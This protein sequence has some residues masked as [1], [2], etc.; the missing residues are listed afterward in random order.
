MQAHGAI[1]F[2]LG[3]GPSLSVFYSC[4]MRFLAAVGMVEHSISIGRAVSTPLFEPP[5]LSLAT[6][7]WLGV[8]PRTS[9]ACTV[10]TTFLRR[11]QRNPH[12][13]PRLYV[14]QDLWSS[15]DGGSRRDRR[16]RGAGGAQGR[17]FRHK[18]SRRKKNM[19]VETYWRA[20]HVF[21]DEVWDKREVV[22]RSEVFPADGAG[23][24]SS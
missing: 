6:P 17:K 2:L 24:S 7:S 21:D 5:S 3:Q 12:N 9:P 1:V 15:V 11:F 19:H 18:G 16:E 13:V 22:Q 4:W 20:A 8:P 10:S 14:C 23:K